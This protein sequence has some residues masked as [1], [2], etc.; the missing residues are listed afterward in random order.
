MGAVSS[1]AYYD[2]QLRVSGWGSEGQAALGRSTVLVVGV[3]GLGCPV[4]TSLARAGVGRLVFVDPDFVEVSNLS[5]QTL[6]S[7]KAVGRQK[8]E[9]A[10]EVLSRANPWIRLEPQPTRVDR[11]S[12]RALVEDADLVVDGTDNFRTKFLLHDACLSAGKPFV[13]GSLYQWEAQ[14]TVFPFHETGPGCWRCLYRKEPE[15]GCVGTCADIGVAGA[16]ASLA[17]NAQ[18]LAAIRILLGQPSLPRCSTWIFDAVQ[19][20]SRWFRWKPDAACSCRRGAGNW[21]WLA[22]PD[23]RKEVAWIH[24]APEDRMVIVDLREDSEIGSGEWDWFV[25]Q[26]SRVIHHAW[27]RWRENPPL[28]CDETT[29]LLVCAHGYRSLS[30]LKTLPQTIRAH[31]LSGGI[32]QLPITPKA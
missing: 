14:V 20:E 28:W 25:S 12:V 2:R 18:A 17:G 3:G 19:W 4:L 16:L 24:I 30:A 11:S 15:D 22:E 29:Y 21:A 32:A 5:R 10:L 7:T 31:S 6:F 8:V 26:G 9:V 1:R 13:L 27:S 23:S